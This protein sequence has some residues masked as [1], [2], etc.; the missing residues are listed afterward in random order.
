VQEQAKPKLGDDFCSHC[1][2]KKI[3]GGEAPMCPQG[4]FLVG[5]GTHA[6]HY[7]GRKIWTGPEVYG[8]AYGSDEL[9]VDTEKALLDQGDYGIKG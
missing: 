1:G 9:R 4:C 5:S 8:K 2:R 3:T 6:A 7:T